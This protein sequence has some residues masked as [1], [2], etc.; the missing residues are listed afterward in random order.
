MAVSLPLQTPSP[1]H[2]LPDWVVQAPHRVGSQPTGFA[3][4]DPQQKRREGRPLWRPAQSAGQETQFSPLPA[5][6]MPFPHTAPLPAQSAG[7]LVHVS[8]AS[9]MPLVHV[10]RS[11]L[12]A[13]VHFGVPAQPLHVAPA[14]LVPSHS[15]PGSRT[16]LPQVVDAVVDTVICADVVVWLAWVIVTPLVASTKLWP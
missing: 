13:A 10:E 11:S 15:S 9:H 2:T 5:S 3:P 8:E 1:Q 14:R 6:Q 12:H 4:P 7:Q 16:P